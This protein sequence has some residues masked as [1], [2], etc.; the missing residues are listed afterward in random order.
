M[1]KMN[2]TIIIGVSGGAD[3]MAL[4]HVLI[5]LIQAYNLTLIAAHIH[6]GLR[7]KAADEDQMLV[8]KTCNKYGVICEVLHIDVNKLAKEQG[9]TVEEAGRNARYHFFN[10]LCQ[11]HQT[12]KV[13]VAHHQNDQAETVVHHFFRGSGLKGL[14]GMQPIRQ[15]GLIRPL[16]MVTREEIEAYCRENKI[17][18]RTDDTNF[19]T[20]YTRN[21]IRLSLIPEIEKNFNPNFIRNIAQMSMLLSDEND[22]IEKMTQQAYQNVA[23]TQHNKIKLSRSGTI[24]MPKALMRRVI[25]ESIRKVKGNITN[26]ESKHVEMVVDLVKHGRTGAQIQLPKG[27][28]VICDTN[29][30]V[31][32]GKEGVNIAP[33]EYD[34]T[35]PGVTK[36]PMIQRQITVRKITVDEMV[37]E[38]MRA[39]VD[40]DQLGNRVTVRNRKDGDRFVPLGMTGSK[41]VKDILIDAQIPK[42]ERQYYPMLC[43]DEEIIWII[44]LRTAEKYKITKNSTNVIEFLVEIMDNL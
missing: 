33:F 4:L 42:R 39:Y 44:G 14:C 6:H 24:D 43:N 20:E 29:H 7:G 18:F 19:S 36:L 3:S 11:K 38:P 40:V 9:L 30:I 32:E 10:V 31:F 28:R 13:A 27:T 35:I 41:K 26:I 2:D 12:K 15:D 5:D 34:V 23:Q 16:L 25:R 8:E 21:A 1:I 17:Q 22:W 37:F